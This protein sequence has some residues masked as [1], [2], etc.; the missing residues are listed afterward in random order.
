[1]EQEP[2]YYFMDARA[3]IHK[4]GGEPVVIFDREAALATL[5]EL[6]ELQP[7]REWIVQPPIYDFE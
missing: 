2:E 6:N 3:N 1:M 4:T 7:E 5:K